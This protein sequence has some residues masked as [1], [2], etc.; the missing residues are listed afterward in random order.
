MTSYWFSNFVTVEVKYLGYF[1]HW[2]FK[3]EHSIWFAFICAIRD[4][5]KDKTNYIF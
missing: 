3:N 1:M 4:L 2:Y 5:E